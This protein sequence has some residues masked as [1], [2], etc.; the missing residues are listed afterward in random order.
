MVATNKGYVEEMDAL[1]EGGADVNATHKVCYNKQSSKYNN[2]KVYTCHCVVLILLFLHRGR[3]GL[4]YF[5]RQKMGVWRLYKTCCIT[6][7]R[8]N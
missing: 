8:L 6:R 7:Q 2:I 4:Q 5:L 1:L 3:G